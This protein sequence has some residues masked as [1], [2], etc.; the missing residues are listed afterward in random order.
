MNTKVHAKG[1]TGMDDRENEKRLPRLKTGPIRVISR[2]GGSGNKEGW[3]A[4]Q[5]LK[6][7]AKRGSP[8]AGKG[9]KAG[10]VS[11]ITVQAVICGFVIVAVLVLKAVNVPQTVEVL[12][13]LD[14]VLT[15][16]SGIDKALGKLKFVGDFGADSTAVFNPEMNGFVAPIKDMAVETGGQPEYAVAVQ[17][18]D[19]PTP[20]LAA[21]DGQV[22]YAG[23][24]PIYGTLM[25]L[26]HQEGYETWYGGVTPEVTTGHT[27][28]AGERIGTIRNGTL[29]F[30]AYRDGMALDPRPYLKKPGP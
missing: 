12:S 5:W 28:L 13:G 15:T 22:F 2:N 8:A 7:M 25:V 30:L 17:V 29:K 11:A 4:R 27:V 19:T 23:N 6:D 16:D 18:S 1:E 10:S 3:N 20:V 21:A 14:S 26:R 24:S 9:K